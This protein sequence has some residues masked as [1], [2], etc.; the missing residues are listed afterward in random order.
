MAVREL[1][2]GVFFVIGGGRGLGRLLRRFFAA[3]VLLIIL[4][5]EEGLLL[6]LTVVILVKW[7]LEGSSSR[8]IHRMIVGHSTVLLLV[9]RVLRSLRMRSLSTM[10]VSIAIVH[11]CGRVIGLMSAL[12]VKVL[13]LACVKLPH[14]VSLLDGHITRLAAKLMLSVRNKGHRKASPSRGRG[15]DG[16]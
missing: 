5:P 11:T 15:A 14:F 1:V 6:Q 10:A 3:N 4:V 8:A 7:M 13:N 2:S 16:S 12:W 9:V